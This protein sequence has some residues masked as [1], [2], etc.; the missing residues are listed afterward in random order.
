MAD[1]AA[2][3]RIRLSLS[4]LLLLLLSINPYGIF[5]YLLLV[6]IFNALFHFRVWSFN[7]S[8]EDQAAIGLLG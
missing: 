7:G 5:M 2:R 4:F 8:A 6:S 1:L 3:G